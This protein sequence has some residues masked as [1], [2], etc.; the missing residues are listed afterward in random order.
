MD[1]PS[2]DKDTNKQVCYY[3]ERIKKMQKE[4]D[5]YSLWSANFKKR[6]HQIENDLKLEIMQK[7][8]MIKYLKDETQSQKDI[9]CKQSAELMNLKQSLSV[10]CGIEKEEDTFKLE[11]EQ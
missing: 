11:I 10:L 1:Y 8:Y 6:Y 9:I 4:L 5:N 2:N 7:D 3:K